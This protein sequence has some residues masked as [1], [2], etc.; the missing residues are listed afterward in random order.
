ML[1]RPYGLRRGVKDDSPRAREPA[2]SN[3][4]AMSETRAIPI[5]VNGSAPRE[6]V[7]LLSCAR[8]GRL[9][10]AGSGESGCRFAT[11]RFAFA[12]AP[13]RL[14]PL[15]ADL[16]VVERDLVTGACCGI[17]DL[18]VATSGVKGAIIRVAPRAAAR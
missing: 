5:P 6:W 12:T 16:R 15:A 10:D 4:A 8:A 14:E 3:S 18:L 1:R 11:A 17:P 2:V 7:T 13:G 9:R